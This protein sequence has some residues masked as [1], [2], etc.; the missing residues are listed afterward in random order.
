MGPETEDATGA[1]VPE[2]LVWPTVIGTL[3][4]V[5][6]GRYVFVVIVRMVYLVLFQLEVV[7]SMEIWWVLRSE[8]EKTCW[9]LA[10][11]V[12][13]IPVGVI[14]IKRKRNSRAIVSIWAGLFALWAVGR[15]VHRLGD[16]VISKTGEFFTPYVF[17]VLAHGALLLAFPVFVMVWMSRSRIRGQ[18]DKW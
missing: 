5:L 12:A 2:R 16:C 17:N 10:V 14:L 18:V 13:A 3:A 15:I 9:A 1:A 6:A 4:I 11:H 7:T 8:V